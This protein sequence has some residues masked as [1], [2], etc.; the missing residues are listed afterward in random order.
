MLSA[1]A[2]N[3][4][5]EFEGC[6][7]KAYYDDVGVLTIGYGDTMNVKEGQIITQEEAEWRLTSRIKQFEL[8]L[9]SMVNVSLNQNEWDSLIS[10]I[11]NIGTAKFKKSTLLKKLNL[12]LRN[13]AAEEFLRWD[14]G[15]IKGKL[16]K[17]PG[18]TRRRKW[19]KEHFLLPLAY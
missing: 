10:F 15:R 4:I 16:V 3:K 5:K 2:L 9:V 13:E 19:E 17:L 14:K 8:A 1:L 7:L 6:R 18:L 12:G 11:Y